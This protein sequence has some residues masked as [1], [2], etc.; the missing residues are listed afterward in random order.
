MEQIE[1]HVELG[2]TMFM[3]EF[4]GRD[5]SEPAALFADTVMRHFS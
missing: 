4:F 1:K 3:I 5:T 2:C